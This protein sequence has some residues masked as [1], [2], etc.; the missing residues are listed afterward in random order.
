M[1]Y[2]K[3]LKI[4]VI[5]QDLIKMEELSNIVFESNNID[6]LREVSAIIL[7]AIKLLDTERTKVAE[8]MKATQKMK[9]YAIQN[10]TKD[11]L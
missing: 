9:Q 5:N 4:A 11:L 7:E 2:I 10:H 6:E 1:D 3:E 8:G